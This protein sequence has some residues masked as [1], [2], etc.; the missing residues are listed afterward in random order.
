MRLAS[1]LCTLIVLAAMPAHAEN[2][3]HTRDNGGG[4]PMCFDKDSVS[5]R[6]DGLTYYAVKMCQD[7]VAQWYAVNCTA[8]FKVELLVRIYDVGST[9]HYRE[10]TVD[11]LQSGMAADADMACHK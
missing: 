4:L 8:N 2:W 7:P 9:T 11:N 5:T 10:F 1:V 3:Q 6:A